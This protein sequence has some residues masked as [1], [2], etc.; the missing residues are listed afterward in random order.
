MSI[1]HRFINDLAAIE[2]N[3]AFCGQA[4]ARKSNLL[5]IGTFNPDDDSCIKQNNAQWFYGRN[6][7]K[8]WRYFPLA[9]TRTSLHPSDGYRGS[10][11]IWKD[12]CVANKI[13]IIDLIKSIEATQPLEDFGDRRVNAIM[14]DN[15]DNVNCF[16]IKKAFNGI[17]FDKVIYSL[18]WSDS[19]IRRLRQIKNNINQSLLHTNCIQNVN[20][21]RYCSTPSRN[22][23]QPSWTRAINE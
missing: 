14:H 5:M 9:L 17:T 2:N 16:N 15:L 8:F 12:Y 6:Q 22:D 23:A 13:V 7:S 1:Q 21:I 4:I 3:Q 18:L 10:P 20:Q 19:T 11:Q